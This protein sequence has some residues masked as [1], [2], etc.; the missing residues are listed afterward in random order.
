M[1]TLPYAAEVAA[2]LADCAASRVPL[3]RRYHPTE[4]GA[5]KAIP[6]RRHSDREAD[7]RAEEQIRAAFRALTAPAC[8]ES[9]TCG[10]SGTHT[11]QDTFFGFRTSAG[12]PEP[13]EPSPPARRQE[14]PAMHIDDR[15]KLAD[16]A[17][18]SA[19]RGWHVF[20]LRPAGKRPAFPRHV[21]ADCD[22]TDPWCRT[23]HRGWEPRATT[24]P[25]RI[26]R[27]WAGAAY[28]VGIATGPSGLVVIDLDQPKPGE[29]PPPR[30]AAPN[31]RDGADVLAALCEAHGEAFPSETFMVRT[32]RGGLHLYFAAPPGARLGN[33]SGRNP[34]GLGWLIDTRA[35]GGYVVAPGSIV[36]LPDGTGRYEVV[37]DRAPAP[38]PA[39][40]AG[41]LT[42]PRP[43]PA[44]VECRSAA[45]DQVRE[46]DT[47][48]RA[49]LYAECEAVRGAAEGGRAFALNKAAYHLGQLIAAGVLD[50]ATAERELLTAASVHF[51]AERPVAPGEA[52][53][54]I[55]G[56]IA[57]GKRRPRPL[58]AP[59][60][61]A[62]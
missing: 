36:D 40:L 56:G 12:V 53:K 27:A 58:P 21:A 29:T 9:G 43:A 10:T 1:T 47:Y 45:P 31:I 41:L 34:N 6:H 37:Y 49:A 30:W 60:E 28:N 19:A 18:Q 32:R 44:S 16:A 51:D 62:A 33:T 54:V 3:D 59:R 15:A 42:A 22:G 5:V 61:A 52:R 23:G 48:V 14:E 11:G 7:Q 35:H 17:L 39:W 38:L 13:P 4:D 2:Y 20:P 57:S 50:D 24:D 55:R 25:G 8:Q 26:R 46:L